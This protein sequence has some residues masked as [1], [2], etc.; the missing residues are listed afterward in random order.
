MNT[1]QELAL[2]RALFDFFKV[3]VDAIVNFFDKF[4]TVK[5]SFTFFYCYIKPHVKQLNLP[6]LHFHCFLHR[7]ENLIYLITLRGYSHY[8]TRACKCN[9]YIQGAAISSPT[10]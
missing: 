6:N 10:F 9:D 5:H 2:R 7:F 4:Y 3:H 8:L 1:L